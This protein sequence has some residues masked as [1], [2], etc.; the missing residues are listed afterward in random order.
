MFSAV[1]L[2]KVADLVETG[3]LG[4][5]LFRFLIICGRPYTREFS[6]ASDKITSYDLLSLLMHTTLFLNLYE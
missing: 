2:L 4:F 6:I 1:Y 5:I 3:N